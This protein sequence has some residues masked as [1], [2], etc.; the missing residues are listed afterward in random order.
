MAQFDPELDVAPPR[1][2]ADRPSI[3]QADAGYL[4]DTVYGM[5]LGKIS[6]GDLPA[7]AVLKEAAIASHLGVSRA[8]V[9]RALSMLVDNGALRVASGQG[10][11]VGGAGPR[12]LSSRE[13]HDILSTEAE[14]ISRS[15]TWERIFEQ[16]LEEIVSLLPFG[17]YRIQE[18]ELGDYHNVS[19]TVA[20]EVLW[21]LTDVRVIEKNRKSHW[22]VGQMTARDVRETFE[23]RRLLEPKALENVASS[24]TADWLAAL[25]KRIDVAV[26]NFPACGLGEIDSIEHEMFQT[27]Y[28]T[29]R[30]ARMLSSIR[31][32][33]MALNV[34]RLFRR[35]FS[36]RDDRPALEQYAQIV[37]MLAL[38]STEAAQILLLR[39]L[40]GAE[41][42]T[43]ARLRVLS[44][45]P[46][47]ETVPYI[48]PFH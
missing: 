34:P 20:R 8:P 2:G 5:L 4:Y 44:V 30:N 19:R 29:L 41:A 37:R 18:A 45:L 21:R 14:D 27:M 31:R 35:H 15:A 13:L 17:T 12:S 1:D 42:L 43:L 10:Y 28:K 32:N 9:R 22:I 23:M 16:V 36:I 7:G 46:I 33:Q 48:V 6:T 11:I 25:A 38:G 39:Y 24:L 3:T 26:E 47:P 40:Q